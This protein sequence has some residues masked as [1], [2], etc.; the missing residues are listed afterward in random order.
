MVTI[1]R[2]GSTRDLLGECP[3]WDERSG[4]LYWAD[5]RAGLLRRLNW[6]TGKRDDFEV[7]AP[8]GSFALTSDG[9]AFLAL[10]DGF[11]S[12]DFGTGE[13]RSLGELGIDHP[14]VR[15]NDGIALPDG[16]FL[17]GT[18]HVGRAADEP[19]LGGLF[20]VNGSGRFTQVGSGI[21]VTNGPCFSPD[22]AFLYLAD[23]AARV[24][25]R[26]PRTEAGSLG[27]RE[28][29]VDTSELGSA[30]DGATVDCEGFIWSALVHRGSIARYTPDGNLD[31]LIE[32]PVAHPTSL[33]FGGD[34]L[35][36]LYVTSI[37]DSGRLMD[38]SAS[39]GGLF[40]IEGLGV[41]GLPEFRV[42]LD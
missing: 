20:R 8:L 23:S 21:G 36:I 30:P 31:R 22:G 38:D 18:M 35:D 28:F 40:A 42:T 12:F 39:A 6:R 14:S 3:I 10:R 11:A 7:P 24:I 15:L 17:C 27:E 29:F 32:L 34:S 5:C 13:L 41:C 2:I 37:S 26:F 1:T 9:Q 16:S 19:P 33:N 25:W 4:A